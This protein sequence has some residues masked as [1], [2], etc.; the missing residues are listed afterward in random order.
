M[1]TASPGRHPT[2]AGLPQFLRYLNTFPAPGDLLDALSRG[3]LSHIGAPMAQLWHLRGGELITV[4]ASTPADELADRYAVLPLTVD[5]PMTRAVHERRT[6]AWDPEAF[7]ATGV[8]AL[9]EDLWSAAL[10]R[11]PTGQALSVPL[12]H[13]GRV[14]GLLGI[15]S[16]E[17]W[18]DPKPRLAVVE[19][20]ASVLALWLTHPRTGLVPAVQQRR[21]WSLALTP[22]QRE[23][24]RRILNGETSAA[25]AR[26]LSVSESSIKQDLLRAMKAMRTNDR[27]VAAQRAQALG[28]LES[29][30]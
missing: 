8:G 1:M 19:A 11:T 10:E 5:L 9:D 29:H 25:I 6:I 2:L 7:E 16:A 27:L 21:E 15:G 28:L 30:K 18:V 17:P 26:E 24:L 23:A 13:D 4:A 14:V 20:L 22:R 3:P 12:I